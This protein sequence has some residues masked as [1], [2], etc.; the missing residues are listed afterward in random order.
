MSSIHV[1]P[2]GFESFGVRSM[3]TYVETAD[4]RVLIDA[5]VALGPRFGKLPHPQE[6]RA[7]DLC[8]TR[9]REL[10]EKSDV[11]VISHYHNDHHTPNYTETVWLGSSAEESEQIYQNK[12]IIAKDA[13]NFINFSQRRRGWMFQRFLMRIGC[14]FEVGDGRFFE[15][16]ETKI[17]ISQP[18]LHGEEH[19]GLGWVIMTTVETGEGKFIHASDVQGPMST[20][21]MNTILAERPNLLVIGGPPTYLRGTKVDKT[22]IENAITNASRIVGSVPETIFEHHILRSE[23]WANDVKPVYEAAATASHKVMTAADYAGTKPLL[24]ESVRTR[25]YADDPPSESFLKWTTLPR[26]QQRQTNPPI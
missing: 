18:V 24:L 16:G 2:V 12:T 9:I 19:S 17:R 20:D 6:Y 5:G 15:Y 4:I 13:R 1:T 7:R 8:R 25:L 3:C 23:D 11:I 26:N 14:K 22:H 21:T 10:S